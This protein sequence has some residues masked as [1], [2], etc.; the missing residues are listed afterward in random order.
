[1]K[2]TRFKAAFLT[3]LI[4]AWCALSGAAEAGRVYSVE[5]NPVT[6]LTTYPYRVV[7]DSFELYLS[8]EDLDAL[9]QDTY[10]EEMNRFLENLEEDL[11]EAREFLKD[12]LKEEVPPVRIFTYFT[13][14]S[15][16]YAG[17]YEPMSHDIMLYGSWGTA[18]RCTLHEYV[19]YLTLECSKYRPING[20]WWE[21]LAEYVSMLVCEN[22]TARSFNYDFNYDLLDDD[23]VAYYAARGYLEEDGKFNVRKYHYGNAAVLDMPYNRDQKYH[24]VS[25][26]E[27][28]MTEMVQQNPTMDTLSYS[29]AACFV[30]YLVDRFGKDKVI[31]HMVPATQFRALYGKNFKDL[32]NEWRQENLK[33]CAEMNLNLDDIE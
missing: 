26:A 1:M 12:Y 5:E 9:D 32:Y 28:T 23:S 15:S 18:A 11:T 27:K 25:C 14:S 13:T 7:S 21:G 31:R 17:L 24:P 3:F 22:K 19:H 4:L 10:F 29:Q 16:V 20:F 8:Q 33:K 6:S 30:E 2:R